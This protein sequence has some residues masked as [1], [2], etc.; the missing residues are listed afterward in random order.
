MRTLVIAVLGLAASNPIAAC[1]CADFGSPEEAVARSW[2]G[3]TAVVAAEAF[4]LTE[5][6]EPTELRE[7]YVQRTQWRVTQHWKGPHSVGAVLS[8][9][10]NVRCCL[11][12]ERVA[13]GEVHLL[14]LWGAEPYEVSTCSV[15]GLLEESRGQIP[16][17]DEL[18]KGSRPPST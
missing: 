6:I 9:E 17:L 5:R 11:C 1:S 16:I 12:G 8:T 15:G 7:A 2:S 18:N 3:A 4:E 13:V 14:Y 10:T